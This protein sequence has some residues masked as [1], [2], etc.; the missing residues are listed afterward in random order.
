MVADPRP[1]RRA[2]WRARIGRLALIVYALM[3]LASTLYRIARTPPEQPPRFAERSIMLP[4]VRGGA[5][6]G[7][8]VRLAYL[9]YTPTNANHDTPVIVLLHGSPGSASNF[10]SLAPLLTGVCP[11]PGSVGGVFGDREIHCPALPPTYTVRVIAPDLPGFSRSTH[12]IADYSFDA[13]AR[14]L[15]AMLDAL[16]VKRAHFVG[17]SMGGGEAL[18]LEQLAP[19]RLASLTLLSSLAAQEFELTGD[20][21]LNR[22]I[23][24]IQLAF[25]WAVEN[26]IPH[27]GALDA[28]P[29]VEF[30]RNF[31]ESDQRPLREYMMRLEKPVLIIHGAHDGQVPPEAAR[32][33]HRIMPHSELVFFEDGGHGMVFGEGATLGSTDDAFPGRLVRPLLSFVERVENGSAP[34]RMDADADRVAASLAPVTL[35]PMVGIATLSFLLLV[36]VAAAILPELGAAMAGAMIAQGRVDWL[37]ASLACAVGVLLGELIARRV[38]RPFASGA[39]DAPVLRPPLGGLIGPQA[40]QEHAQRYAA[41]IA[42]GVLWRFARGERAANA[43]ALHVYR[44]VRGVWRSTA[45]FALTALGAIVWS[46]GAVAAASALNAHML[47]RINGLETITLVMIAAIALLVAVNAR[48]IWAVQLRGRSILRRFWNFRRP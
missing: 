17:Y 43:L 3:L 28:L 26:L 22:M 39:L 31:F 16:G 36:C 32:E 35:A 23:H 9:D 44:P 45:L 34:R 25:F 20:Y 12:A 24:G 42:Q 2:L 41:A 27:F 47:R 46:A 33:H 7:R 38:V 21:H 15:I 5:S 6:T 37:G 1:G 30:A 29:G 40:V 11:P 13:H 19:E 8:Q 18:V 10:A 4:E 14:Y 48:R